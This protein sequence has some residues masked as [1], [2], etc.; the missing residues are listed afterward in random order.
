MTR[1]GKMDILGENTIKTKREYK[2][3]LKVVKGNKG[4]NN[5]KARK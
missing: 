1:S 3:K 5:I 2:Y 4:N